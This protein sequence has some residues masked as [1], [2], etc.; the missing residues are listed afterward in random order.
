MDY[1]GEGEGDVGRE[2]VWLVG[3]KDMKDTSGQAQQELGKGLGEREFGRKMD[4]EV[5]MQVTGKTGRW[6]VGGTQDVG[7]Y[8]YPVRED[9]EEND[10]EEEKDVGKKVDTC[11]VEVFGHEI[12]GVEFQQEVGECFECDEGWEYDQKVGSMKAGQA[13]CGGSQVVPVVVVRK[14]SGEVDTCVNEQEVDVEEGG[15]TLEDERP[16]ERWAV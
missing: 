2:M 5:G 15:A 3:K 10:V 16:T 7:R 14:D 11:T 13:Q 9:K 8:V 12:A 6:E 1:Q 4:Q